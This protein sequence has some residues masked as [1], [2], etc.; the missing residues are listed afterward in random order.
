M[1]QVRHNMLATKDLDNKLFDYIDPSCE[2]LVYIEWE[3]MDSY[4]FNISNTP[5]QAANIKDIISN[6]ATFLDWKVITT[7]IEQQVDIY[8]VWK[9]YR[10]IRHD[11]IVGYLVYV[12]ITGI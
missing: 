2:T 4:R 7:N 11:Y 10:P 12:D 9:K 5:G 1:H 6:L 3:K 8:D